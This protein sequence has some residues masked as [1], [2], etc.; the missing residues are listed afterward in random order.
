MKNGGCAVRTADV[1]DKDHGPEAPFDGEMTD[2]WRAVLSL[3][4]DDGDDDWQDLDSD[5]GA[6]AIGRDVEGHADTVVE[7]TSAS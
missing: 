2:A 6:G 7:L 4:G 1:R 5:D 3:H